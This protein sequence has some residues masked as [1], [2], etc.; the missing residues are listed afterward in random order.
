[1]LG[2]S[3]C[4][5]ALVRRIRSCRRKLCVVRCLWHALKRDTSPRIAWSRCTALK[6]RVFENA[7]DGLRYPKIRVVP[8]EIRCRTSRAE[9]A[10]PGCATS[11]SGEDAAG[12]LVATFGVLL[13]V[14]GHT[15]HLG[16]ADGVEAAECLENVCQY[17]CT[18]EGK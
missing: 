18:I 4:A 13:C 11:R 6:T 8:S 10:E 14:L 9:L 17:V 7:F 12:L 2:L 3:I 16:D 1:L 5:D 15:D